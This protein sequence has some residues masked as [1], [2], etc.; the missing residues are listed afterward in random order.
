[1]ISNNNIVLSLILVCSNVLF[2]HAAS[3]AV[4]TDTL[5]GNY[6]RI[7]VLRP[8]LRSETSEQRNPVMELIEGEL[9]GELDDDFIELLLSVAGD[10]NIISTEE[11]NK[12]LYKKGV[13]HD[14]AFENACDEMDADLVFHARY[15]FKNM[16][17]L[18][19]S[20]HKLKTMVS[21]LKADFFLYDC[22]GKATVWKDNHTV[23]VPAE[24]ASYNELMKKM[25]L[26]V[27]RRLP[28]LR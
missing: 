3:A 1:M 14:I 24:T 22:G 15:L 8:N 23:F 9:A 16:P 25:Y 18:Y 12:K 10:S 6:H 19:D 4:E 7:L 17:T 11:R 13:V 26:Y 28:E 21:E 5:A 27:T 20:E 2:I